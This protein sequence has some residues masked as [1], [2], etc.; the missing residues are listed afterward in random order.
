MLNFSFL[1]HG[2]LFRFRGFVVSPTSAIGL[3]ANCWGEFVSPCDDLK[4]RIET[5]VS[6]LSSEGVVAKGR[7]PWEGVTGPVCLSL[8][9]L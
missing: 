4:E 9:F 8:R 5:E 3:V 6:A 2:E 7:K 1:H